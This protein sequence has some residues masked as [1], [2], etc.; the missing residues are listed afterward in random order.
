[1]RELEERAEAQSAPVVDGVTLASVHAAK[2]LEWP[3]VH[4]VGASDGLLPISMAKTAAEVEEERRLF[5]VALTRARDLLTV[6]WAAARTPPPPT[7]G[8]AHRQWS[9]PV[10]R[11]SAGMPAARRPRTGRCSSSCAPGAAS[12][13]VAAGRRHTPSSPTPPWKRSPSAIRAVRVSCWPS[14]ASARRRLRA[15][16]MRFSSYWEVT[17]REPQRTGET[18]GQKMDVLPG[19]CV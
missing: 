14:R 17:V 3:V 9:P 12:A 2:G 13:P 1:V 5:Y 10:I 18:A 11:S 15:T 19:R 7:A 16:A 6:S 4:V 8:C